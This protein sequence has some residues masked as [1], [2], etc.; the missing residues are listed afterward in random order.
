MDT[1]VYR[2]LLEMMIENLL[3][4]LRLLAALPGTSVSTEIV[5]EADR[6]N[7][8]AAH[9]RHEAQELTYRSDLEI[10]RAKGADIYPALSQVDDVD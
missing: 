4:S 6:V 5:S 7:I 3:C 9:E 1:W 10:A 8:L 2:E